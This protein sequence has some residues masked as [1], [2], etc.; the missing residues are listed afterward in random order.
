MSI[1]QRQ[2]MGEKESEQQYFPSLH[3]LI[4]GEGESSQNVIRM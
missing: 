2:R 3:E 4:V 1:D